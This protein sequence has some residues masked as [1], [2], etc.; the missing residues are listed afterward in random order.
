MQVIF[1]N[2]SNEPN[3]VHKTNKTTIATYDLNIY[4]DNDIDSPLNI[5]EPIFL[6]QPNSAL[7]N[8]NYCYVA[9]FGR[10]Y[11]V[12]IEQL[13]DGREIARCSVDVLMSFWDEF[14]G[15]QCIATRS[16]SSPF[17]NMVDEKVVTTPRITRRNILATPDTPFNT[18]SVSIHNCV[19]TVAGRTQLQDILVYDNNHKPIFN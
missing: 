14:K 16:T 6:L 18:E 15:S 3:D 8:C 12:T 10:Y 2:C 17:P 1:Y 7:L 19:L 11:N 9:Q 4:R 5:E 13:P